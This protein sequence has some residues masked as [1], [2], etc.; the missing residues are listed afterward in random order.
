MV[1]G[2]GEGRIVAESFEQSANISVVARRSGIVRGLLTL[3]RHKLA[4]AGGVDTPGFA[5]IRISSEGCVY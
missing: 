3:W 5:P 1:D 4:A 2:A